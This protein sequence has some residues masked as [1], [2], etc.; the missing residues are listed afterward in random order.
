VA[1]SASGYIKKPTGEPLDPGRA[2]SCAKLYAIRFISQQIKPLVLYF[3]DAKRDIAEDLRTRSSFWSK[4]VE[5]HGL[6][7]AAVERIEEELSDINKD[8]VNSSG[9]FTLRRSGKS[10]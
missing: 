10:V 7:A 6:S 4:M 5:E 2:T 3:W 9:V 1:V 8:I